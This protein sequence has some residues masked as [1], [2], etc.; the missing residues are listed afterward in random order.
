MKT[1]TQ[2]LPNNNQPT[3][4]ESTPPNDT[5]IAKGLQKEQ[6]LG[7]TLLLLGIVAVVGFFSRRFE[8]ALIFAGVLSLILII[9][10]IT[11]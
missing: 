6:Y 9:F 7:I 8:Y 10:F 1:S 5:L 3:Y 11:V 4:T 2:E